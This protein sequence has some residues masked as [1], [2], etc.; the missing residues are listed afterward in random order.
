MVF[1]TITANINGAGTNSIEKLYRAKSEFEQT[2]NLH[3]VVIRFT[4]PSEFGDSF[5][6]LG[7]YLPPSKPLNSQLFDK[8]TELAPD[9]IQGDTNSYA[10]GNFRS[11]REVAFGNFVDNSN[12]IYGSNFATWMS[13]SRQAGPD[14]SI[15]STHYEYMPL[16]ETKRGQLYQDHFSLITIL[17]ENSE[18]TPTNRLHTKT[19]FNYDLV[20]RDRLNHAFSQLNLKSSFSDIYKIWQIELDLI[21]KRFKTTEQSNFPGINLENITSKAQLEDVFQELAE[22]DSRLRD[23]FKLIKFYEQGLESAASAKQPEVLVPAVSTQLDN[24]ER[25]KSVV[26][27]HDNLSPANTK[28]LKR[29]IAWW[30]RTVKHRKFKFFSLKELDRAI[31]GLNSKSTSLDR[32]SVKL[33]PTDHAGKTGF[34]RV[35]N[36]ELFSSRYFDNRLMIGSMTFLP[37]TH[38]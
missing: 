28:T 27:Q 20:D 33:F 30:K 32:I 36:R 1:T 12:L 2:Y 17:G 23:V 38:K 16:L 11:Q 37:K 25:Y 10:D 35:I 21:A 18:T 31:T 5:K 9:L 26:T 7:V 34:L 24:W 15:Y 3:E 8:L 29:S 6:F 13:E 19:F 22:N 14:Q 4:N